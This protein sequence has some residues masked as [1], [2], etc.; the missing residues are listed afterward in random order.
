[1]AAPAEAE[2]L[3]VPILAAPA[4]EEASGPSCHGKQ[5]S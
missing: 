3:T 4:M 2:A 1:M 5:N